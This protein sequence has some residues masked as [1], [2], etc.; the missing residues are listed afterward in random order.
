L[1]F[2]VN[3]IIHK[4]DKDNIVNWKSFTCLLNKPAY[5]SPTQ[6]TPVVL[7]LG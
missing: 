3:N 5:A 7:N 6:S 2:G 1:L 4:Y